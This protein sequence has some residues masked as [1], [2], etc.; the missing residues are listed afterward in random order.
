MFTFDLS[1][2]LIDTKAMV[3]QEKIDLQT[4]VFELL[5]EKM[6]EIDS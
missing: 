6:S 3:E 1:F 5:E 4:R 2:K